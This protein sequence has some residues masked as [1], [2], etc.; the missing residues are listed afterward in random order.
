VATI[1]SITVAFSANLSELETGIEEAL[2]FFDDLV[3]STEELSE[4]L[5]A[6][7]EKKIN[8][9][10]TANTEELKQATKDVDGLKENAEKSDAKVKVSADT[11]DLIRSLESSSDVW[12]QLSLAFREETRDLSERFS[13]LGTSASTAFKAVGSAA[14]GLGALFDGTRL[15][16][17]GL[18]AATKRLTEA[19][20][21]VRSLFESLA[22]EAD[23][24]LTLVGGSGTVLAAFA[25]SATS[26]A[27]VIAAFGASVAYAA[28]RA[29][30]FRGVLALVRIAASGLSEES[31]AFVTEWGAVLAGLVSTSAA[32]AAAAA[33]FSIMSSSLTSASSSASLFAGALAGISN[34]AR[35][36]ASAVLSRLQ[37]I[38]VYFNL[39]SVASG[40]YSDSLE[41]IGSKA[42]SIRNMADR[43]G[44][45]TQEMEILTFA[46]ES[47]GVSMSQLAK[48]SQAFYTN[49]SKVKIGQ[50]N[51]DSVQEAKF[52]FDRLGISINQLRNRSP[53]EVFSLVSEELLKVKDP[54]DRAAI[55]FDLFGKQAV[56]ILP[57]LKGLKEAAADAGRLG[58]ATKDIDFKMFEGV[59]A[60]F[61]RLKQA[62]G[63]LAAAMMVAFAPLQ[64]GIN[65]FLADFKGGLV[66]ALGPIRTVMAQATQ[67]IQVILEISGRLINI[68][69]RAIGVAV[70]FIAALADASAIGPAWVA[71][72]D[73][74]KGVLNYIE[75]AI[76]FAQKVASAF[77]SQMNPAVDES[78]S[79]FGKL[80]FAAQ[81]FGTIIVAGGVASAVMQTFGVQAGAALAKFAAGLLKVNFASVFMGLIKAI[82][83]LTFDVVAF[84]TR[85]VASMI[86]AGVSALANLL[87]PFMVTVASVITGNSAMAVSAT[88]T[89]W[90]MAAAWIVGTL[91]LAAIAVAIIAVIQNFST[92]YDWFSDFG[93]NIGRLFT[94]DG[95]V[96][97]ANAVVLAIQNAFLSVFTRIQGFFGR[98][99]NNI[100]LAVNGIQMP[101]KID[102]ATASVADVVASRKA[103][104][105]AEYQAA[106]S[107]A[108]MVGMDTSSIEMP[109]ENVDQL[110]TMLSGAREEMIGLSME[111]TKFGEAGR[112]SF[113]AARADFDKLQQQFAD[114]AV[115][116]SVII[117]ESGVRRSETQLEAFERR[118]KEIRDRLRENLNLADV[119]SPEAIQ[120]SAED[121][122]KAIDGA[123]K[124]AVD[125]FKGQDLGSD[126]TTSRLF[127]SSEAIK[128]QAT[129]FTQEYADKLREIEARLQRGE[130]GSGQD[131]IEAAQNAKDAETT[132]FNRNMDKIK[133]DVSFASDIR[134]SLEDAFLS[135]VQK[136]QKELKKIQDNKSLTAQEK[137]LATIMAQ[138]QMVEGA[139]GKT[140]GKSLR[141]KE[142]LL[143]EASA[144]DEYGRTAFMSSEGSRA[145]GDA[146]QAAER[147]KLDIERRKAAGLDA[148][149][150]Q[151]LQAGADNIADIFNV[152]GLSMEEIKK[153][154]TPEQFEEYQ[155][156]M[157][158][159]AEAVKASLG[160]EKSGAQ[161][162]AESRAK[163]EKAVADGVISEDEKNKV[164]KKQRDELLSSLG[165]SK[166]PAQ[167]FEDAVSKIKENAAELSPE[168]LTKGL[169]AAKDRLLQSLGIPKSPA[170]AAAESLKNLQEAFKKGQITTEEFAK[171]AMQ[172]KNSLLQSLG[173]PLDPVQQLGERMA[174]LREA[175]AKRLI[176]EEEF[177]RGQ[178]EARR[179][180][181]PGGEA[182]SPVKKFQRDMDAVSRAA[183]AGLIDPEDAE[184]RKKVLQA[185]LQED[186]KPAL[187]RLAPDR[188]AVESSDVRSKAG[189][190]TFFRILRGNDNP[191]LKAQ[192]EIA[193][194]TKLLADAAAEPLAE[195]A[196]V[197][198][199]G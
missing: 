69:L 196:I 154:L 190:D 35:Q 120:S 42:E 21:G 150:S 104:Q 2:G 103:T 83:V 109:A 84:A 164:L 117:D 162:I 39:A 12:S 191:S 165:I 77:A 41:S 114:G 52:A 23:V 176:S 3:E 17:D 159:N 9:K 153:K 148:T 155:E 97:A 180:M 93:N 126:L 147:N 183:E 177:M 15:S 161:K 170:D 132:K 40:R 158:K 142:D 26:A 179:A 86:V 144:K 100:I 13:S 123:V 163:L 27:A 113:L 72:G 76:D 65:N 20:S 33:T 182:E 96:E 5:D 16:V 63:N 64:T 53:Q 118:S 60:S 91:G 7:A 68:L 89:G 143:A 107:A 37:Q 38:I 174:D 73:V 19:S 173:I 169:K 66:A 44:Q 62:S 31:R 45:T 157:K 47:A 195:P 160:V 25:G 125:I 187:D 90:A 110:T 57:A 171:G 137:S 61:D 78:A 133:A 122:K 167:D 194:N 178:E 140:A 101:E 80:A 81:A 152:T 115:P 55:A 29:V 108:N 145:A 30:V 134:K 1:G 99:I 22:G 43:F 10:A 98:I 79:L 8:I 95:L 199:G 67:P 135:P 172:A 181:I 175:F 127:P 138:Q 136:F 51:V 105:G 198:M 87:A 24:F 36:A 119:L 88:A 14:N 121:T 74:I 58:T 75:Q 131:A 46:A 146:R 139:F 71:L 94:W 28:V 128:E 168:E 166:T 197:N 149:A 102:A 184:Q 156:A 54:A 92:L 50:L 130:F 116:V 186:L 56:N 34:A 129:S 11:G 185:Q 18:I 6:V 124:S 193:K 59:D 192:L 32:A 49:V 48:A 111:A 112:K 85:W 151:Q 70:T 106:V 141:E 188:R 4:K 82:R 189:V